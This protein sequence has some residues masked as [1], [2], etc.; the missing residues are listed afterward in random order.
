MQFQKLGLK[1]L[2][3]APS[4]I[5][6]DN[7]L[8]KLAEFQPPGKILRLGHPA[9]IKIKN[10][11][12]NA[13]HQAKN[14]KKSTQVSLLNYSVETLIE[15]SDQKLLAQDIKKELDEI[16]KKSQKIG[17]HKNVTRVSWREKKELY[18]EL[19]TREN[20]AR[21]EVYDFADVVVGT[22]TSVTF[23]HQQN[24][25]RKLQSNSNVD[26]NLGC[27]DSQPK[28]DVVI[29]DEAS[30]C[31]EI[32]ALQSVICGKKLVLAGDH[33]QLPPTILSP[34]AADLKNSGEVLATGN[35]DN[36]QGLEYTL[37]ERACH[38]FGKEV[39]KLLNVQYRMNRKIMEWS[40]LKFYEN[41]VNSDES[42]RDN[43]LEDWG[44]EFLD[45]NFCGKE[46]QGQKGAKWE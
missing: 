22:T 28:F 46:R 33:Q 26:E 3:V 32:A 1:V 12:T 10:F 40:N 39:H 4:N 38:Y 15:N 2:A 31:I 27:G 16:S 41:Q 36:F 8:M 44:S 42:C 23:G 6:V 34:V 37:L 13:K 25:K 20:K 30:Q 14:R 21:T 19:K 18:A 43:Q 7:I 24:L 5:A 29:I 9:R 35:P 17:K 11:T 45:E